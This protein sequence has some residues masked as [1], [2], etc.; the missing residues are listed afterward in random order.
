MVNAT[1]LTVFTN[2]H[3][4]ISMLQGVLRCYILREGRKTYN[5]PQV[6][7]F[8]VGNVK[9][10]NVK[11]LTLPSHQLILKCFSYSFAFRIHM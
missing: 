7:P 2:T 9:N 4:H 10:C 3:N 1:N 5:I 11:R 6:A 8:V